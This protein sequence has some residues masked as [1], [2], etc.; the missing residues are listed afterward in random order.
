M[1]VESFAMVRRPIYLLAILLLGGALVQAA[2]VTF[3]DSDSAKPSGKVCTVCGPIG[4]DA[5]PALQPG[6]K[7]QSQETPR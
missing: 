5:A 6:R 3:S 7:T 4:N 1:Q 2:V